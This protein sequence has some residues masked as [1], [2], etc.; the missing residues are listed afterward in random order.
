MKNRKVE[1]IKINAKLQ[2]VKK[3]LDTNLSIDL[4]EMGKNPSIVEFERILYTFYQII[5]SLTFLIGDEN[6]TENKSRPIHSDKG[7]SARMG[8]NQEG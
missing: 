2:N 3:Q 7:S 5:E 1:L 4:D 6:A 8:P